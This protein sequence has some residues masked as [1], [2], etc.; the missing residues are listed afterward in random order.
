MSEKNVP[1]VKLVPE[2]ALLE[3]LPEHVKKRFEQALALMHDESNSLA[4]WE[5]IATKS[6]ISPFHFHRQF[7][8]LFNET[9]GQYLS[10]HRLQMAVNLLFR[11]QCGT[12]TEIA[13]QCGFSSSQALGKALKKSLGVTAKQVR[14]MAAEFT[15]T[16][17][18]EFIAKLAH[19]GKQHSLETE[20]AKSIKAELIWYPKRSMKKLYLADLNWD[21]V[22]EHFGTKVTRLLGATPVSQLDNAWHQ[23]EY[24]IGDWTRNEAEHDFVLPEGHYLCIEV[25]FSTDVAYS[26]ALEALFAIAE[27]QELQIDEHAFFVE[28]VREIDSSQLGAVTFSFQLP[29]VKD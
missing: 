19:P 21:S 3:P 24:V 15:P 4:S 14:K 6:A 28:M 29:I 1:V 5:Q 18:A 13:Q 23:I 22:I 20:L 2:E 17:S 12:V 8:R 27:Q 10:R 16:Q 25:L 9:P 26:A 7:S 11:E